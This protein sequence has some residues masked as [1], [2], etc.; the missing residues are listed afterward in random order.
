MKLKASVVALAAFALSVPSLARAQQN[1]GSNKVASGVYQ[2]F[3]NKNQVTFWVFLRERGELGGAQLL[4]SKTAKARHVRERLRST[5]EHSQRRLL[6]ELRARGVAHKPF[7]ISNAIRVTADRA[8]LEAIAAHSEVARVAAD[9]VFEIPPAIPGSAQASINAVDWNISRIGAD[10]VWSNFGDTGE[11]IVI[12]NIDTGVD[13]THE[14]LSANYRGNSGGGALVQDYNFFDPYN[15]CGPNGSQPCDTHGHG[16]H[17]MGTMAGGD[18]PGPFATDIGVAPGARWITAIG[19]PNGSCPFDALMTS[20][21]WILAPTDAQGNNPDPARAPHIVNNSWGGGGGDP[22]YQDIVRAWVAAGIFPAFSNGNFGPSCGSS[23]SPGDYPEAFS[24]GATDFIDQIAWFSSRGPS[25]FG[26]VKPDISAPGV[27]VLSSVPGGYAYLSGTSM[28]SPHVAGTVALLWAAA[29]GLTGDIPQTIAILRAT[30]GDIVDLSCGGDGDGDPNNTYGDGMLNAIAAVNFAP[31]IAGSVEGVVSDAASGLGLAGVTVRATRDDDGNER[32]AITDAN[33][34]YQLTLAI[35]PAPGP[36]SFTL[37]AQTFGYGPGVA[38]GVQIYQDT[39]TTQNIALA[40]VPRHTV[41][42]YVRSASGTPLAGATVTILNAPI[43]PVVSNASG[44]YAISNVPEGSYS[45]SATAGRCSDGQ[46][47][48]FAVAGDTSLDFALPQRVD[49]FGYR[50]E[51]NPSFD[52]VTATDSTGLTG[53]ENGM[54]I[55]LPFDFTFYGEGYSSAFLAINGF[56]NF[57]D[58]TY[59][60]FNSSIPSPMLPNAAVYPFWDDLYNFSSPIMTETLG[61][62]PNRVFVIEW[63]DMYFYSASGGPINFELKLHELDGTIEMLYLDAIDSGDGRSATVGIENAD[64]TIAFQYSSDEAVLTP[65][66]SIRYTPPALGRVDGLVSDAAGGA[67]LAGATVTILETGRSTRTDVDGRYGFVLQPGAYTVAVTLAGYADEQA[68]VNVVENAIVTQD[69]EMRS[70]R[71]SLSAGSID[72][73]LGEGEIRRRTVTL[74]NIGL[75]PLTFGTGEQ[76]VRAASISAL[77]VAPSSSDEAPAGYVR[78]GAVATLAGGPVLVLMDVQPW[79]TDAMFQLLTANG[80]TFDLAGSAQL[81]GLDLS[82]YDTVFIASDQ[83]TSFYQAYEASFDLFDDY[84]AN[85]GKLWVGA[86]AWGWNGGDFTGGR[87]PGGATV[88]GLDVEYENTIVDPAHPIMQG[89][90]N[91]VAGNAVS[92]TSFANL[93]AGTNILAQGVV[94]GRPTTIEYEYGAG[95]VIAFGQA[96]EY[97]FIYENAQ[98]GRMLENGIPYAYQ[99]TPFTDISWLSLTPTSG[100]INAGGQ[101]NLRITVDTTGLAAGVYRARV[102]I[103]TND[104]QNP[105]LLVPVTLMVSAYRVGVNSGGARFVDADGNAWL[106]DRLANA[107]RWG[108][109]ASN[110]T[111]DTT[112]HN[113]IGV[114]E[115]ELFQDL[116]KDAGGYRFPNVPNGVYQVELLFAELD[117]IQ[118]NKRVFDV[119]IENQLVLPAFDPINDAGRFVAN[120]KQY[121][122][123]VSDGTLNVQLLSRRGYKPPIINALRVTQRPDR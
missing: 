50:C 38:T 89:V 49:A 43:A 7:W 108:Y 52:Y 117:S 94:A 69:F 81:G 33:G 84:V 4:R 23:G 20:G 98:A 115:D 15:I 58:P 12:A 29:P 2:Q 40:I 107:T 62:A 92:L 80:I 110:S 68:A 70:P 26:I 25:A 51:L 27:D 45:A 36:E 57:R 113:I 106:A 18:G 101:R 63:R 96:L 73:V 97:A 116:R 77:Q 105:R 39:T 118:P 99:L 1:T 102:A 114:S 13:V 47:A 32:S 112:N 100:T 30:A 88:L 34:Y 8:T 53:D 78:T 65:G 104:P 37:R 6:R 82:G 66:L 87:L 79:G 21:E 46:T 59:Y 120:T 31:R 93:P 11:G 48:S 74:S 3:N 35:D 71:A 28:A 72:L 19:C 111:V 122:V 60:Y 121:F 109:T 55:A 16:T 91:P 64:G 24:A 83:P 41:S 44:Y 67:P 123:T 42:G 10:Q 9:G 86:S 119:Y 54:Q 14:A 17:T 95:H 22:F 75:A 56:L 85:G 61:T 76:E 5:A 103:T 90:P